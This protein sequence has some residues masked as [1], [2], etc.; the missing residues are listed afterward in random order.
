MT[1]RVL[2]GWEFGG[3]FG[4]VVQLRKIAERLSKTG[5]FE[6]LFALQNPERGRLAGLPVNCIIAAPRPKRDPA[7]PKPQARATY[8]EFVTENL[9]NSERGLEARLREWENII[10]KF[11]PHLI[12]AD[13][14][15]S[16][17][18]YA[19][20]RWP[21]LAIGNGYTLPPPEMN[22]FPIIVKN[23]LQ[24]YASEPDM[25][26]RINRDLARI[27]A[28]TIERL[29]QLNEADAY[30]VLTVP[31]LDPYASERKQAYL[32][33]EIPDGA[34]S[35]RRP[36]SGGIA[37]FHEKTQLNDVVVA[38]LK[39]AEIEI[40]AYLGAPLRRLKRRLAGSRVSLSD[41]PFMLGSSM[42]GKGVAIHHGSLGFA[43]SALFAGVPQVMLCEHGEHWFNA[44][45]I[46]AA[47]AGLAA[48]YT[49]VTSDA[50]AEAIEQVSASAT[51]QE[52]A[53]QL[54]TEH[55]KYKDLQP[56]QAIADMAVDLMKRA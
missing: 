38:G 50:L 37:Y 41:H 29:P 33:F 11:D 8:G 9:M 15:P 42:P 17:T 53:L 21:L 54:A 16:L 4:H 52:R 5:D 24:P 18:L 39:A 13:Y 43:A 27:G 35:L 1:R 10:L 19:R 20:G 7:Y 56:A 3:G 14:A 48:S 51:M 22:V 26:S 46:V 34:P 6:F 36:A 12:L 31:F 47:G 49:K 2:L 45:K 55:G 30:G 25:I 40:A 44:D 32:G 28:R 23:K